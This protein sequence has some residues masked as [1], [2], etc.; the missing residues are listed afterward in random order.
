M[1]G[2]LVERREMGLLVLGVVLGGIMGIIGDLW[3]SYF[4]TWLEETLTP[5][6]TLVLVLTTVLLIICVSFLVLWSMKQIGVYAKT[7]VT[8][9]IGTKDAQVSVPIKIDGSYIGKTPVTIS[10]EKGTHKIEVPESIDVSE[11][12]QFKKKGTKPRHD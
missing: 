10:L 2:K 3:A 7:S 5:N 6:W 1:K 11:K 12:F 8:S 4:L 9:Q